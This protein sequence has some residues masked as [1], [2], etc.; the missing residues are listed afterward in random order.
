MK[1]S[2]E[3]YRSLFEYDP[4]AIFV[5]DFETL[6]VLDANARAQEFYGYEKKE[7]I[8]KSFTDL[9]R[10]EYTDG[11]LSQERTMLATQ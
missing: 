7:L 8:G 10:G 1:R 9:G 3:K 6:E 5:L 4:N 2:E 11:V